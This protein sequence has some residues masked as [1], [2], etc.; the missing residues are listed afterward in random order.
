MDATTFHKLV[1]S[2]LNK[3]Y[4]YNINSIGTKIAENKPTK[5][6]PDT[7]ITLDNNKYIF[8]EYT[9]QK[10]KVVEKFIDDIQKCLN[11]QKTGIKISKIEKIIL[12]CNSKL[13][14]KD[15]GKI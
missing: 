8:V 7:L 14:L 9:T 12:A 10:S 13:L 3:K 11:P 15:I 2:Y 6:T 5:G 4:G 1:D